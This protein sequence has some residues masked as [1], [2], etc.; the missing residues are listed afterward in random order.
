MLLLQIP[1]GTGSCLSSFVS[2][3]Q[4]ALLTKLQGQFIEVYKMQFFQRLE[5]FI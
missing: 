5:N 3:L 4:Y 2:H 1:L